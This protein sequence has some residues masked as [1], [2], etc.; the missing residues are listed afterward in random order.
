MRRARWTMAWWVAGLLACPSGLWAGVVNVPCSAP[1]V[2]PGAAVNVVVVPYSAPP[3]LE[4]SRGVGLELAR[5]VQA[6]TLLSIARYGSV[7]T[8]QL[9]IDGPC[10]PDTVLARL[11]GEAPGARETV[12]PGH[13]LVL[14]WGRIFRDGEDIYLQSYIR[15]ARRGDAG[16]V[17]VRIGSETFLAR[18]AGV[19]FAC[20]PRKVPLSDLAKINERFQRTEVLHRDADPSSPRTPLPAQASF[21]YQVTEIRGD[22]MHVQGSA[23]GPRGWLRAGSAR[24]ADWPLRALMPE[25]FF[26]DGVAGYLR[27]QVAIATREPTAIDGNLAAAET[28]LA[29]YQRLWK[30]GALLLEGPPGGAGYQPL[31]VGIPLQI[32]ALLVLQRPGVSVAALQ[33]AQSWLARAVA[34]VPYSGDARNLEVI[35]RLVLAYTA[36]QRG[37]DLRATLSDLQQAAAADPD[38][39]LALGNVAR[40]CRLLLGPE[41]SQPPDWR[42][43]SDAE[44]TE[45]RQCVEAISALAGP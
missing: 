26:V 30:S 33:E 44:R 24:S 45:L 25:L 42:P 15:F 9:S 22:W 12:R 4:G 14:V 18:P 34:L 28:A 23:G 2:F 29:D 40:L 31:A 8:V 21:A 11:M 17:G 43:L 16:A 35:G 41:A 1:T 6:E 36:R 19:A 3:E 7:G 39:T 38:N 10:E 37:I 5:L 27:A 32:R 13:G 20:V